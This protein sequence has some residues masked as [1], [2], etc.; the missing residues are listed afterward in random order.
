MFP[1]ALFPTEED[2]STVPDEKD[3]FFRAKILQT[4]QVLTYLLAG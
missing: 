4:K 3:Y 1:P 2:G